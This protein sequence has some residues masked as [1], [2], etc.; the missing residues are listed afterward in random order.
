MVMVSSHL[1]GPFDL[2]VFDTAD[3]PVLA[4]EVKGQPRLRGDA[5]RLLREQAAEMGIPYGLVVDPEIVRVLDLLA[6]TA[7]PLLELSTRELLTAYA[8]GLDAK[9]VTR[10]YLLLLVDSW[11][12]NVMQPLAAAPPP[13]AFDRL[14]ELGLAAR[15]HQGQAVAEWRGF[16]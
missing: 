10:Q 1:S 4:V 2:L 7:P 3:E 12:R 8:H 14:I 13:P 5:E 15:L 11:L 6:P 16:A 9:K